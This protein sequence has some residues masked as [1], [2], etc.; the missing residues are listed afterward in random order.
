MTLNIYVL[1]LENSTR[2]KVLEEYLNSQGIKFN[3]FYGINGKE[4]N[5]NDYKE[6]ITNSCMAMCS[7]S[8]IG[9]ALSHI[10]IWEMISKD[11]NSI[12][13]IIE[14]DTF[15]NFAELNTVLD[16]LIQ[17]MNNDKTGIIQLT[18]W[19]LFKKGKIELG[20]Y[21]LYNNKIHF[22][23]GAYLISG[24][25]ANILKKAIK[26]DY[27]IDFMLN[28]INNFNNYS[29]SPKIAAQRGWNDSNISKS[30]KKILGSTYFMDLPLIKIPYTNIIIS[31]M[32]LIMIFIIFVALYFKLEPIAWLI[33]GLLFA[34]VLSFDA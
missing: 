14:D 6:Y 34:D 31:F 29:I 26:I 27:H 17:V 21:T 32:L 8:L 33:I 19:T 13:L 12:N 20:N 30:N 3:T 23:L 5:K 28:T 18:S 7:N 4:M 10:K 24:R 15:V 16:S 11:P 1:T 22:T 2:Y 25:V 9:C